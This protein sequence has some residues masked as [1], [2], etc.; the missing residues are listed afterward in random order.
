MKPPAFSIVIATFERPQEMQAALQSIA[1][2][3]LQPE[4]IWVVDASHSD[5]VRD[6]VQPFEGRLPVHRIEA[7]TTSAAQQR[8]QGAEH[9][10]TPL[11][12]FMD[13]DAILRADT[14]E[15]MIHPFASDTEGSI[16]GVAAR[17]DDMQHPPPKGLLWLYYRLQAGYSH[18]DYGARLFGPGINCLPT[19]SE[20]DPE[21]IPSEWLNS[22]CVVY[23]TEVFKKEKFPAFDGYSFMEDVHLSHRIAATHALFF[24]RDALYAHRSAG[25]IFKRDHRALA[26][27]RMAHQR[28]LARDVLKLDGPVFEAKFLLHRLFVSIGILRSGGSGK[29]DQLIGTWT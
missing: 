17:I 26:R 19:Y 29:L 5:Q 1:A 20:S 8:N 24:H 15:K 18:P 28:A 11:I 16:G 9:V 7:H 14:L 3:T 4:N 25:S 21:L 22:T 12:L 2:S 10:D 23:R 27:S 13:D 6:V